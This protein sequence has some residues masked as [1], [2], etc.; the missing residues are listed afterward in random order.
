MGLEIFPTPFFA[1]GESSCAKTCKG[2]VS[3]SRENG[4]TCWLGRN[5]Q[6]KKTKKNKTKTNTPRWALLPGGLVW[7][8]RPN[9]E[10]KKRKE[11]ITRVQLVSCWVL[12]AHWVTWDNLMS[13]ES[14]VTV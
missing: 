7:W 4:A 10:I 1:T 2:C 9:N 11:V 13:F 6:E 14:R 12:M 5:W 3:E 8:I